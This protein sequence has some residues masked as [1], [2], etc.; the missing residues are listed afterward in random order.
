MSEIHAPLVS[1]ETT[2]EHLDDPNWAI[3]DVR[4]D[5]FD[6]EQGLREY[7][8][9]HIPGAFHAHIDRDLSGPIGDGRK[10]RHPLPLPGVF[11]RWLQTKGV[12]DDS[13]VVCYDDF[14]G[15]YAARLWWM[16]RDHGHAAVAVLDGGWQRWKQLGL[17]TKNV[18]ESP[19]PTG[20]FSG[21]SGQMPVR[22]F[23]ALGQAP[24]LDVRAAERYLGDVEPVDKKAGH[25]P[26]ALNVPFA[27]NLNSDGMFASPDELSARFAKRGIHDANVTVYCGSGVTAAHAVLAME[28]A[29]LGTP[30]LFPGSWSEYCYRDEPIAVGL[31]GQE[32]P[33]LTEEE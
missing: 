2:F 16:I 13:Q 30:A 25:I 18:H 29:E 32:S 11:A 4:H 5:L 22:Q 6:L 14:G 3:F 23:E 12:N 8:K 1:C 33:Q 9:A 26:G 15:A 28:L 31:P 20:N 21:A 27:G 17:R 19:R 10:G 7:S 24:L